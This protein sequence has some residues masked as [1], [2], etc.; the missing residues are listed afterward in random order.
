MNRFKIKTL[1]TTLLVLPLVFNACKKE[2]NKQDDDVTT[3]AAPSPIMSWK[4]STGDIN[5]T[6]DTTTYNYVFDEELGMH[7][8]SAA[9]ASGRNL[10]FMLAS[11]EPGTYEVDFDS[12]IVI[13]QIGTNVYNGGFNPQGEI[14]ITENAGGKIRGTFEATV[15]SFTTASEVE[16]N[17]GT[18]NLLPVTN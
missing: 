7:V 18:F 6:A 8:L 10:T 13:W 17:S 12:T 11:V 14:N 9:D 16:I 1:I 15:F 5:F 2:E 3:T 4:M